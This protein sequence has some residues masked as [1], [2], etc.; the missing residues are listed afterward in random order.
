MGRGRHGFLTDPSAL[1][2]ARALAAG[3][4]LPPGG[5]F[6]DAVLQEIFNRDRNLRYAEV[7][8]QT[9]LASMLAH[10]VIDLTVAPNQKERHEALS[11]DMSRLMS[12][13]EAELYGDRYLPAFQAAEAE[14]KRAAERQRAEQA[15]REAKAMERATK[16]SDD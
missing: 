6:R 16:L 9:R 12:A 2:Q 11:A 13:F 8:V 14:K 15:A 5:S 1:I 10:H 3:V 7:L 4:T